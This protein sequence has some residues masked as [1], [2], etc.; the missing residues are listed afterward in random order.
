MIIH[1]L[2]NEIGGFKS[3]LECQ[4]VVLCCL[5]FLLYSHLAVMLSRLPADS[6]LKVQSH[7]SV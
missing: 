7:Y 5:M 2:S 6:S 4:M 1:A 3:D